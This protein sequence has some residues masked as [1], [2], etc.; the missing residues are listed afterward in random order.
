MY[1]VYEETLKL[2][3]EKV[4]CI[5]RIQTRFQT[6][7]IITMM[8]DTRKLLSRSY[9]KNP[10]SMARGAGYNTLICKRVCAFSRFFRG[11]KRTTS[12]KKQFCST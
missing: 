6:V 9:R 11:F 8:L 1:S 5:Y 10:F 3:N 7:L 2:S 12:R 4:Y